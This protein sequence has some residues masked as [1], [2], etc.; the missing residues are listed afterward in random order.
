V[1]RPDTADLQD[2]RAAL[3]REIGTLK[4]L[5]KPEGTGHLHTTISVLEW[6]IGQ[7]DSEIG[8]DDT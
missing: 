3:V 1:T 2:H 5:I 8:G 7:I 6:R 4:L